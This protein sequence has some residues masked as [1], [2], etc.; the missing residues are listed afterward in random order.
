MIVRRVASAATHLITARVSIDADVPAR[1]ADGEVLLSAI[2]ACDYQLPT[3]M[4][5]QSALL[6]TA[7]PLQ[8]AA[9]PICGPGAT[10]LFVRSGDRDVQRCDSCRLLFSSPRPS[11]Q[12]I[13]EFFASQYI[14]DRHRAEVDFSSMRELTLR[15]EAALIRRFLPDGGRLLDIGC[16]SGTFMRQFANDRSWTVE[17][18]EPSRFAAEYAR[19]TWG[20]TVHTGFLRD[21]RLPSETFDAITS[22]DSFYFHPEPN[23]DLAEMARLIPP[24]GFLFMEIPGL[25]FRLAKNSGPLAYLLFGEAARLNAGLHLYFY[26]A[27][28]LS[29]LAGKH[30]FHLVAKYAQQGP[31]YGSCFL[32]LLNA[33]YFRLAALL[34]GLSGG[35]L[36]GAPKEFLVFQRPMLRPV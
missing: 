33:A 34:Y 27:R 25:A 30:G 19:S 4:I 13:A 12:D 11:Q 26:S 23:E 28:T 14:A 15:R 18:V 31:V 1:N 24:G 35:R 3:D 36:N 16:A 20:L 7:P 8:V 5:R 6:N 17:G 21:L 22:L 32:R 29:R 2:V 9:C 10:S